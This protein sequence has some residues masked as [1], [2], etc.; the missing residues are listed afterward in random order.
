[1]NDIRIGIH[2]LNQICLMMEMGVL[3]SKTYM[4]ENTEPK[5]TYMRLWMKKLKLLILEFQ[6]EYPLFRVYLIMIMNIIS[7]LYLT[8]KML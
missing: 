5:K 3:Y 1:M 4:M 6:M 7:Y 2:F 8:E